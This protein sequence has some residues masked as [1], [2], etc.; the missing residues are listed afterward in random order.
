MHNTFKTVCH[1][2][3][4]NK[5]GNVCINITLACLLLGEAI[6][7]THSECVFVA[8][9]TQHAKHMHHIRLSSVDC[10]SLQYFS[11]LSHNQQNFWEKKVIE[12]KNVCS[13][14]ICYFC[15][16]HFSF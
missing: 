13:D 2:L 11:T 1:Y 16:K 8:L 3:M 6:S 12:H 4:I 14:F 5:I 9:V 10:L 7:I 15:M